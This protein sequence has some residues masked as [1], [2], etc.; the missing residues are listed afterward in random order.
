V[1]GTGGAAGT[2]SAGVGKA[3]GEPRGPKPTAKV[4]TA[5]TGAGGSSSSATGT[6]LVGAE[7]TTEASR[8]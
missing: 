2:T 1:T 5:V 6:T 3:P 7:K 8:T 4:A